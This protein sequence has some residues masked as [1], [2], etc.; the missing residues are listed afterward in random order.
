[1]QPEVRDTLTLALS[2]R[3]RGYTR[4]RPWDVAERG[5]VAIAREALSRIMAGADALYLIVLSARG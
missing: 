5:A 3:E 4:S 2:Q 1:M